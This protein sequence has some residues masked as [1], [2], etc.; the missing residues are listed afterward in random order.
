[1]ISRLGKKKTLLF[2]FFPLVFIYFSLGLL[3]LHWS[4]PFQVSSIPDFIGRFALASGGQLA[5]RDFSFEYPPLFFFILL[6]ESAA[7]GVFK[8]MPYPESV[9]A[10]HLF[11]FLPIVSTFYLVLVPEKRIISTIF[12]L[13]LTTPL[14]GAS[15]DLFAV[16]LN[17][18]ALLLFSRKKYLLSLL[19]L[20]L[21]S[22]IK[23]YPLIYLPLILLYIRSFSLSLKYF[24]FF[25]V[26][27]ALPFIFVI[28]YGGGGGLLDFF[29]FHLARGIQSESV[30]ASPYFLFSEIFG[31]KKE[32]YLRNGAYEISYGSLDWL[33]SLVG[34]LAFV[35]LC[36]NLF[37]R[38]GRRWLGRIQGEINREVL[39]D[40]CLCL[41]L[42]L[43]IFSKVLSIQFILWFLLL[44]P[45]VSDGLFKR[46]YLPAL[47]V[48]ILTTIGAGIITYYHQF[49]VVPIIIR[50]I[51][52]IFIT[53]RSV[54]TS[55][56]TLL[57]VK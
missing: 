13:L 42:F 51:I 15:F 57:G 48:T 6:I 4:L 52:L 29:R 2:I 27:V 20:S 47:L 1:M 50:N 56:L 26:C 17:V 18:M 12:L 19:L 9:L 7:A 11:L 16:V 55:R 30:L 21:A 5:Y 25:S 10:I 45:F 33:I 23:I 40:L 49:T 38:T 43:L 39:F 46:I 41:T 44:I 34:I 54:L 22:G 3:L 24:V 37:F 28:S 8:F 53:Y 31:S 35:S 36:L 14:M 32:F